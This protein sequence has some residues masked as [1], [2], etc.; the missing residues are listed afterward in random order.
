MAR[1]LLTVSEAR[2]Y[3]SCPRKHH[4][5]YGLG[6]RPAQDHEALRFGHLCHRGLEA[7]WHTVAPDH[8]LF[9][10]L[11]AVAGEEAE[12]LPRVQ[13]EEMLRGYDE[14]WRN[15]PFQTLG[16]EVEFRAN[17]RNPITGAASRTFDL[18]GKID[19]VAFEPASSRQLIIEHKTSSS[20]IGT[21]SEYWR[22]LQIDDQVSTYFVGAR[23]LGF[24][25]A[26]CLYDV[27]GKPQI[28]PHRATPSEKRKFKK[29]GTLYANQRVED[30]SLD[31]YRQRLQTT[32]AEDPARYYQR[33]E[34][35]RLEE[36]EQEAAFDLWATGRQIREG[37]LARRYPR[38]P[39]ACSMYNRTCQYFDVCT[40]TASIDDE[41]RF[42]RAETTHEELTA[43]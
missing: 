18:G 2:C 6:Y 41:T 26:A 30:E 15:E 33:G 29:D 7:W 19:A 42:R 34:V 40:G 1:R 10:A 35:V 37:E 38:N 27:L 4:L 3:R 31:E 13:C 28:R 17:M 39:D 25:P 11:T 43:A 16:V 23:S 14:R 22:R 5:S 21:G 32:I 12:D 8:R 9:A 20:D 36:E 24:E